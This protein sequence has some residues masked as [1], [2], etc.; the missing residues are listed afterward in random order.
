MVQQDDWLGGAWLPSGQRASRQRPGG[1]V[2][3]RVACLRRRLLGECPKGEADPHSPR[4]VLRTRPSQWTTNESR[5]YLCEEDCD[6][7]RPTAALL[8]R[9]VWKGEKRRTARQIEAVLTIP[10]TSHRPVRPDRYMT[11]DQAIPRA[12]SNPLTFLSLPIVRPK[13][14]ERA[15]PIKTQARSATILPNFIGHIFQIH[16]GKSYDDVRIT[17]DMVGHK[18]GEFAA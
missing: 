9:S 8:K 17:E 1:A 5:L 3:V 15:P 7:M 13:P 14:G 12:I 18:L 10:R 4:D 2:R 6:A 16:N 11:F